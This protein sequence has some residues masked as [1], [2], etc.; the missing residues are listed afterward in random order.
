MWVLKVFIGRGEG[1]IV[2]NVVV[3]FKGNVK[4]NIWKLICN[5]YKNIK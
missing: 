1:N 2:G 5:I 3:R 4:N